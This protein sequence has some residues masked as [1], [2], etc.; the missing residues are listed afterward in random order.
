MYRLIFIFLLVFP[1]NKLISQDPVLL[2]FKPAPGLSF[3]TSYSTETTIT[4]EIMGI[5]QQI[6]LNMIMNTL[7]MVREPRD[8]FHSLEVSYKRLAIESLTPTSQ[9][10]IDT[11]SRQEQEGIEYLKPILNKDFIVLLNKQGQVH[12]VQGLDTIIKKI[13]SEI[14]TGSIEAKAYQNTLNEAFGAENIKNNMEHLSPYYPG[15]PIATGDVWNYE[16]RTNSAQFEIILQNTARVMNIRPNEIIIQVNSEVSTPADNNI[17]I[18]GMQARINLSGNQVAEYR[19]LP[20]NGLVNKAIIKQNLKG[21][22]WLDMSE[23]GMGNMKIPMSINS[24]VEVDAFI[25]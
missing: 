10:R 19:V 3:E 24:N 16:L 4:Q 13:T 1:A 9:V 25:R 20:G 8:S 12:E 17:T 21:Q 18:E 5:E 7:T 22:I 6:T 2:E 11:D 23:Q 14:E 15:I